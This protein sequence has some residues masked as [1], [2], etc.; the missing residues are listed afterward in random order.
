MGYYILYYPPVESFSSKI[1]GNSGATLIVTNLNNLTTIPPDVIVT[2]IQTE[3]D[4]IA[5]P[6]TIKYTPPPTISNPDPPTEEFLA[7]LNYD[8]EYGF[9]MPDTNGEKGDFEIEIPT[10]YDPVIVKFKA[11][12]MKL[13]GVLGQT[14]V[15]TRNAD[16]ELC[17]MAADTGELLKTWTGTS[18]QYLSISVDGTVV[19]NAEV[20]SWKLLG[21]EVIK[22]TEEEEFNY[23]PYGYGGNEITIDKNGDSY[24]S[25]K[26]FPE[27]DLYHTQA[28]VA[29]YSGG[30]RQWH[31]YLAD[32][33]KGYISKS[34][35]DAV[36][37]DSNCNV[38]IIINFFWNAGGETL[39]FEGVWLIKLD[40]AG[41]KLWERKAESDDN[42]HGGGWGD[43]APRKCI[44]VNK[45]GDCV[46]NWLGTAT[47]DSFAAF[48]A[49]GEP[50]W[51]K[52]NFVLVEGN[53]VHLAEDGY[54]YIQ[55]T[56]GLHKLDASGELVWTNTEVG[57][58]EGEGE[59]EEEEG[60]GEEEEGEGEEEEGEGEEEEGEEGEGEG[61][62]EEEGEGEFEGEGEG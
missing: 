8:N 23:N 14:Y 37:V 5:D 2:Y 4:E 61:E 21:D 44:A 38:Y 11:A 10:I 12:S 26:E 15:Y 17:R 24:H 42:N 34:N 50:L 7:E 46:V 13:S 60:E 29:K 43:K 20:N 48:S 39:T 49:D 31:F 35:L 52:E 18:M 32:Y 36:A 62:E 40:S 28:G 54:I 30:Q 53:E 9:D 22:V 6:P 51:I 19:W 56:D 57:E 3:E 55:D 45:N 16:T 1:G 25:I 33:W 47:S 27:E 59:E 41:N 58:G